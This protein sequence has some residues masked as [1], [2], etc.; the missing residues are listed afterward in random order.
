MSAKGCGGWISH[1]LGSLLAATFVSPRLI[2]GLCVLALVSH[3]RSKSAIPM[4]T[5]KGIRR[6]ACLPKAARSVF[7]LLCKLHGRSLCQ[8]VR[9]PSQKNID[10]SC[11]YQKTCYL[12]SRFPHRK[13]NCNRTPKHASFGVH[14]YTITPK[15][16]Q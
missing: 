8:P 16:R 15:T 6:A 3:P 10:D 12:C 13:L 9:Y 1:L 11:K 14:F 2:V 4:P 7:S 5:M